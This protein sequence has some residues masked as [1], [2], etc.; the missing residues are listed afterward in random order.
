MDRMKFEVPDPTAGGLTALDKVR[1]SVSSFQAAC[2][3]R[4]SGPQKWI[5]TV[6]EHVPET[7]PSWA[8]SL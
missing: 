5:S 2:L 7:N 8:D 3:V 6:F 4:F 1:C